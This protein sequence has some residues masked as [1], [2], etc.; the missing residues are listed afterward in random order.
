MSKLTDYSDRS[1]KAGRA[2]IPTIDEILLAVG[3]LVNPNVLINELS[4]GR[5]K[6]DVIEGLQCAIEQGRITLDA[7]GGVVPIR[8]T[9]CR[10]FLRDLGE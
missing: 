10:E 6:A 3:T 5:D 4:A 1:G 7:R 2:A 8:R 9:L